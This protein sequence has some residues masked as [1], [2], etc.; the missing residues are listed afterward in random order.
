MVTVALKVREERSAPRELVEIAPVEFPPETLGA[1]CPFALIEA[2]PAMDEL[3][4]GRTPAIDFDRT[5]ATDS[6]PRRAAEAGY[7][8]TRF[9][10]RV[11]KG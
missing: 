4:S 2:V 6:V 5:R 8:V 11:W 7:E 3:R 1:V 9:R 10:V